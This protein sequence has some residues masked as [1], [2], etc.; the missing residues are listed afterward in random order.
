MKKY[1]KALRGILLEAITQFHKDQGSRFGASI[2]YLTVFS[3]APLLVISIAIAGIVF[4]TTNAETQIIDEAQKFLGEEG[5][6]T[7]EEMISQTQNA[8]AGAS[9]TVGGILLL[10]IGAVSVFRELKDALDYILEGTKKKNGLVSFLKNN[11]LS[12]CMVLA[13]GFLLL[14][15]LII[16]TVLVTIGQYFSETLSL[17][18]E[19]FQF[20]NFIT[21]LV[22]TA[23]LFT[24]VYRYVPHKRSTWKSVL[25][26]GAIAALLFTI[27]K[28]LIAFYVGHTGLASIYGAAGSLVVILYWIYYS[29]QIVLLG[30]EIVHAYSKKH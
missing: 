30:G 1:L 19:L 10:F 23:L 29:S 17:P 12:F 27:G 2:A 21:S 7:I 14:I 15:S 22:V 16:S 20:I 6:A 5:A 3:L 28:T 11:L 9:F 8:Q 26:G 4:G 24:L 18:S 25:T 13:T